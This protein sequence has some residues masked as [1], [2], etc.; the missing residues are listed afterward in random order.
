MS[1]RAAALP[2]V[3][4]AALAFATVGCAPVDAPRAQVASGPELA[5]ACR[6]R[7]GWS[8][9]APPAR[10]WG[11]TYFVGTC[12]ITVLL[13]T[14]PQGHVLI[15]GATAQ[16]APGVVDNI[17]RLRFEPRDVELLLS[18]HEHDDHA[19]GLA[20]L[21]RLTGAKLVA[22]DAQRAG[23]ETGRIDPADPQHGVTDAFEGT[24]VGRV[25]RD[26]EIVRLGP[27]RLTAHATPG[28][29]GGS[30]SWT[31]NACGLGVCRDVAYAD[32]LTAVSADAYRFTDHPAI[33]ARF[34]P[35]FDRVAALPCDI[36]LTPHPSA[37]NLFARL[38][39]DAPLYRRGGCADYAAG[40][41]RRFDERLAEEG[42]R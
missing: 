15:D 4:G 13:I 37:S 23:L 16:A 33:V 31:W 5:A 22:R 17:R 28:H 27:L 41:R 20:T 3:L 2:T 36:L 8:D 34:G 9:P 35:T 30:T 21:A 11:N 18:S 24:P 25:V 26:G 42:A 7:D 40:A 19:G 1:A 32:S 12:G 6:G 29:T 38:A 14:S 10:I 39:G